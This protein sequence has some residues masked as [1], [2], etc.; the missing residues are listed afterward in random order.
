VLTD[1]GAEFGSGVHSKNKD[2]HPFERLLLEMRIKHRYTR[3]YRPQTNGKVER[4]WKTLKEDFLDDALY[5]DIDD[6]R[7]ELLGFLVYYNKHRP[8]TALEN[9]TPREFIENEKNVSN[10]VACTLNFV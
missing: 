5:E 10:Y 2:S 4:F 8:H 7:E 6:L 9:L 3:P 1:N